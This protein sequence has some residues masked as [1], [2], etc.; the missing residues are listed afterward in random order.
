[1]AAC[2]T[3]LLSACGSLGP[4]PIPLTV[5]GTVH[6]ADGPIAGAHVRLTAYEN[7]RCVLLARSAAPPSQQ[8]RQALRECARAVGEAVTDE[9]GRYAFANVRPGAYDVTITWTLRPDQA[10]PGDPIFDQGSYA[11]V[12]VRNRD[13]T[14]TPTARSVIVALPDQWDAIQDF[15]FQPPAR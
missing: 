1:V 11:V 13:E 7:D 4:S 12:I 2:L 10:V 3:L 8:D 5:A 15:T 9:A 6:D 14:W